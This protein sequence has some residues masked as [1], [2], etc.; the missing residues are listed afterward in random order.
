MA[1]PARLTLWDWVRS[2]LRDDTQQQQLDRM[3]Q[4]MATAAEQ[5]NTLTT[6]VDDVM[7]DVRAALDTLRQDRENLSDAGQAAFDNLSAKVDAFDTEIGDADGSDTPTEPT[8]PGTST[9]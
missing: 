2:N 7:A 6:K 9:F 3:E 1:A 4:T 5:L 8:E